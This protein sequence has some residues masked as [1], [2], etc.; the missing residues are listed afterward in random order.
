MIKNIQIPTVLLNILDI[1]K[2]KTTIMKYF[3]LQFCISWQVQSVSH[4]VGSACSVDQEFS[5]PDLHADSSP[6]TTYICEVK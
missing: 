1:K 3:A 4:T 2:K 6:P 5:P